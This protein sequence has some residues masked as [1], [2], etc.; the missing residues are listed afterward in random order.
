MNRR[1]WERRHRISALLR[2]ALQL[3]QQESLNDHEDRHAMA[4]TVRLGLLHEDSCE[5]EEKALERRK[6]Y[7]RDRSSE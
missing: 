5:L 1:S 2:E 4:L 7:D 6:L 3:A